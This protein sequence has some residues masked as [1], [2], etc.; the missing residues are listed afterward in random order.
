VETLAA[1]KSFA[2]LATLP[3]QASVV[4]SKQAR[5]IVTACV[6]TSLTVVGPL[7]HLPLLASADMVELGEGTPRSI[8]ERRAVLKRPMTPSRF[9]GPHRE[10]QRLRIACS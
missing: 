3:P 9:R 8:R 5:A 2:S 4:T 7:V 10:A 1:S 6:K